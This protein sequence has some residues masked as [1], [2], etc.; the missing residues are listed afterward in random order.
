M[1]ADIGYFRTISFGLGDGTY[2]LTR[3]INHWNAGGLVEV[4]WIDA[5]PANGNVYSYPLADPTID[6]STVYTPGNQNYDNFIIQLDY[7]AGALQQLQDN[8]VVVLF[9]PFM[10]MNV[11]EG[12]PLY[13]WWCG[14][15]PTKFK[16]FWIYVHNYF[17][18]TKG[19]TNLLWVYGA[20]EYDWGN[21][22]DW[23]PG[24]SYVD[25]VG[26][27]YYPMGVWTGDYDHVTYH[28]SYDLL[29][30]TGKPLR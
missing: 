30:T 6:L 20:L 25:V 3:L 14:K 23:Y 21:A 15:D 26:I 12:A 13:N 22:L 8:G 10:E 17:T 18:N 11:P 28:S 27:D 5:N 1:G 2:N 29:K 24:S 19:L 7:V 4:D 16:N 9:R